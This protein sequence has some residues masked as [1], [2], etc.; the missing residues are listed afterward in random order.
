MELLR[1]DL[2]CSTCHLI[3]GSKVL[4]EPIVM[5]SAQARVFGYLLQFVDNMKTEEVRRFVR[6]V[7]GSSALVVD[8]INVNFNH[9]S[10][11]SHTCASTLELPTSCT[12]CLE[13][14]EEFFS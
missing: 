13:F 3:L 2:L 9:L 8:K 5:N 7:T 12:I 6:F 10:G 14:C 1:I 4:K 11:L